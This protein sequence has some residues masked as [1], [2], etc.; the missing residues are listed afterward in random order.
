MGKKCIKGL[1]AEAVGD[2]VKNLTTHTS[3]HSLSLSRDQILH[4]ACDILCC[5]LSLETLK[6]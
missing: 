5:S 6:T 2:G 3:D 1:E 4:L